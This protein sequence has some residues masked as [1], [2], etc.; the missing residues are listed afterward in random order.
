MG[1]RRSAMLRLPED[2]ASCLAA[3]RVQRAAARSMGLWQRLGQVEEGAEGTASL[4]SALAARG[5]GRVGE[6]EGGREGGRE[7][8]G[9]SVGRLARALAVCCRFCHNF[10]MISGTS[11]GPLQSLA[12]DLGTGFLVLYARSGLHVPFCCFCS[13][14]ALQPPPPPP[15]PAPPS[16]NIASPC[17][18]LQ[19]PRLP[20]L[21]PPAAPR[22]PGAQQPAFP[23]RP[24]VCTHMT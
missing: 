2:S 7:G 20:L 11:T 4:H 13:F 9:G 17:S 18:S 23:P 12:L 19:Q 8:E 10:A 22:R 14:F 16:S 24:R 6:R 3:R 15:P 5:G 1:A 21:L